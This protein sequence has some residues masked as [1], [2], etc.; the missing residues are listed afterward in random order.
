MIEIKDADKFKKLAEKYK[1][2]YMQTPEGEFYELK[3]EDNTNGID[4]DKVNGC[5]YANVPRGLRIKSAKNNTPN[6]SNPE[7]REL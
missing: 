1:I 7:E 5:L 3:Q 4:I 2:K 6:L